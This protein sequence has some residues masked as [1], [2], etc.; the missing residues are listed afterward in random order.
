MSNVSSI[1]TGCASRSPRRYFKL[2]I[3]CR[4][5]FI[6]GFA[7]TGTIS[8]RMGIIHP[9][10]ATMLMVAVSRRLTLCAGSPKD[11]KCMMSVPSR[12]NGSLLANFCVMNDRCAP[13]SMSILA[14]AYRST[15]HTG[16]T[17][18]FNSTSEWAVNDDECNMA[19]PSLLLH[20]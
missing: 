5:R 12:C 19:A 1:V 7:I 4:Q 16:E 2:L 8:T 20:V 14:S 13:S 17:A 18:V 9:S 11:D 10:V 3:D 15:A 6:M